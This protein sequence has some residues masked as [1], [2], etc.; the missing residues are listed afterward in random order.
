[1]AN[2]AGIVAATGSSL[3]LGVPAIAGLLTAMEAGVP[4]PIPSDLVVL[5]LGERASAGRVSVVLAAVVLETVAVA[6]TGLLFLA[7]RGPGRNVLTRFGPRLG[8][9]SAR[10]NRATAVVERRGPAALVVGR[11][12]PGLRTVTVVAAGAS[13]LSLRRALPPLVVGS[14]IFLQLHLVLGYLLGPAAREALERAKGP[15]VVILVLVAVAGVA[16]WFV[17]RGKRAGAQASAEACCPACLALGTLAPRL[18][19][20]EGLAPAAVGS[21]SSDGGA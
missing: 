8:L 11:G 14:S 5:V 20:V 21:T 12:T 19:G 2:S 3:G 18:F 17:A 15:V 9:T 4:I 16:F 1:M 6:G 7:A 13:G 10:L